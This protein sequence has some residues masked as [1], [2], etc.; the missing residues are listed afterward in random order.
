MYLY[1]W[2]E[3]YERIHVL[4]H[5]GGGV[6]PWNHDQYVFSR[7]NGHVFVDGKPLVFYHFHSLK[8]ISS[9]IIVP[10]RYPQY[11]PVKRDVLELCVT[12]YVNTIVEHLERMRIFISGFSFGVQS[13]TPVPSDRTVLCRG[14]IVNELGR[15]GKVKCYEMIEISLEKE[16]WTTLFFDLGNPYVNQSVLARK[17]ISKVFCP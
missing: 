11:N 15:L 5:I 13:G 6:A 4:Q 7:Q 2:P 8:L 17:K 14:P 3:R 1:G 10:V 12:P 9:D 16:N